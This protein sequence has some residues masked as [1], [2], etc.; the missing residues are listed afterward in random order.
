MLQFGP[1]EAKKCFNQAITNDVTPEGTEMF[2][3]VILPNEQIL[4]SNSRSQ[5]VI[6]DD[7]DSQQR[8]S[9]NTI[10]MQNY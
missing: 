8:E 5:V 4:A 1:G 9:C 2:D 10:C 7:D 3:L 6:I